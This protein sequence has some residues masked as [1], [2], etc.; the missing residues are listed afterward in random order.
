[1]SRKPKA[2]SSLRGSLVTSA[3]WIGNVD[4]AMRDFQL[5][6]KL[7]GGSEPPSSEIPTDKIRVQTAAGSYDIGTPLEIGSPAFSPV[8]RAGD[9]H[10]AALRAGNRAIGIA[11]EP[12][13]SSKYTW[14]QVGGTCPAIVDV[15]DVDHTHAWWDNA[16]TSLASGFGGPLELVTKPSSTGSQML[17]VRFRPLLRRQGKAT[18]STAPG[19]TNKTIDLYASGSKVGEVQ[20]DY[21]WGDSGG[22]TFASGDELLVHWVDDKRKWYVEPQYSAATAPRARC[23][24]VGQK[25]W[26]NFSYAWRDGDSG[27]SS[28]APIIG[29]DGSTTKN[30]RLFPAMFGDTSNADG[31]VFTVND[32]PSAYSD[33]WLTLEQSGKYRV[34]WTGTWV[35]YGM[36]LS[37]A[38]SLLRAAGHLHTA[39]GGVTGTTTPDATGLEHRTAKMLARLDNDAGS[40]IETYSSHDAYS[41]YGGTTEIVY[42][43]YTI[44]AYFLRSGT[45]IHITPELEQSDSLSEIR[46]GHFDCFITV[47]QISDS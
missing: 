27:L 10:A 35:M 30:V 43:K 17:L 39:P 31:L 18:T 45:D 12:T 19:N 46:R 36:S 33:D 22:K 13:S 6:R 25:I 32:S 26:N 8:S 37:D 7:G 29:F 20:A 3:S 38:Q 24:I 4:D 9:W 2:G 5:R 28:T 41:I 34:T 15:N 47:E 11:L 14:C 44:I 40:T 42:V 1:M 16:A 21:D 23:V